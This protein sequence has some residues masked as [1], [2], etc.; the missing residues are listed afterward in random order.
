MK[1]KLS[2]LLL[3]VCLTALVFAVPEKAEA[4]NVQTILTGGTNV[5]A[6][7]T[8]LVYSNLPII[9]V[10]AG[11]TIGLQT[12]FKL[13]SGNGITNVQFRIDA[14][15]DNAM[16]HSNV[17]LWGVAPTAAVT[18]SVTTNITVGAWN[19]LRV[20]AITNGNDTILTNLILKASQK[21]GF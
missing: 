2:V 19:F 3:S 20:N 10:N 7:N 1:N 15:I 6:A 17:I 14:S 16:W 9:A 12:S 4:Q 18:N 11:S 5:V 21:R 8:L 13:V